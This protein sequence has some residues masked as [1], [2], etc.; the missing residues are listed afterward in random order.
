MPAGSQAALAPDGSQAALA[1]AAGWAQR[2]T[3]H[4]GDFSAGQIASAR[5]ERG[6]GVSVCLPARECA[7]TIA[8]AVGQLLELQSAGVIDQLAVVD[9]AS[10]DGTGEL[11][12][13]AGA[14]VYQEAALMSGFGPV[15]GKGDAMWRALPVLRGDLVCFLDADTED[16]SPHSVTGLLGP[17]VCEQ[18]VSLVKAFYR[19]PL[20]EGA[21]AGAEAEGGRVNSLTARPALALFY[22]E[23]AHVCQPLAGEVAARRELLRALPFACGYGVEVAMLIDAWREL[24]LDGIAQVDLEEHRHRHQ[25][26]SALAPMALTV[27]ATLARRL[28]RDGTL[29][30]AGAGRAAAHALDLD[31]HAPAER[32]PLSELE[33]P[34]AAGVRVPGLARDALARRQDEP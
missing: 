28:E 25:P 12:A 22:P 14:E 10:A 32:P 20:D 34:A 5:A 15:L 29:R 18:G 6:L 23:L 4:H 33:Q 19:R 1:R 11:A 24:G 26:L 17:L 3:Y 13:R 30:G 8:A 16:F 31:A 9:A 27:L 7:A 2:R 21:A